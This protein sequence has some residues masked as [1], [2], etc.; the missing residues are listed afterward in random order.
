MINNSL[1]Y[2]AS[3]GKLGLTPLNYFSQ[4]F[5]EAELYLFNEFNLYNFIPNNPLYSRILLKNDHNIFFLNGFFY[6]KINKKN[7]EKALEELD[8]GNIEEIKRFI[9][10]L[11]GSYNG[12]WIDKRKQ[13]INIFTDIMG[14]D[15]I[16][17]CTHNDSLFLSSFIWPLLLLDDYQMDQNAIGEHLLLGHPLKN[18]TIFKNIKIIQPG[19]IERFDFSGKPLGF[20]SFENFP[21]RRKISKS[22]LIEDFFSRTKRHY[23]YIQSI[24]PAAKFGTTLTG[25]N[26]TRVVLNSMLNKNI[27]PYCT[28]GYHNSKSRDSERADKIA[29]HYKLNFDSINYSENFEKILLDTIEVSNG[30]TNGIWMGSISL[31]ASDKCDLLYNGFSGDFVAGGN[32]FNFNGMDYA[33]L[34]ENSLKFRANFKSILHAEI[35]SLADSSFNDFYKEYVSSY[36][37]YKSYSTEDLYFLQEKNERNFRRIASFADGIR[38]GKATPVFFFHDKQILDFYRSIDLKWYKQQRLHHKLSFHNNS[39]LAWMPSANKTN[40]PSFTVPYISYL[41]ENKVV[42]L[43]LAE[44]KKRK[45]NNF[46]EIKSVNDF[47]EFMSNEPMLK[48][49]RDDLEFIDIGAFINTIA[50]KEILY[51]DLDTIK[52]RVWDLCYTL[53]FVKE[54]KKKVAGNIINLKTKPF[55]NEIL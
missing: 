31:N 25:G 14:Y 55:S 13:E 11:N 17:Y 18:K 37:S 3:I 5:V 46:V 34:A 42:K 39:F 54:L 6:D 53:E 23:N 45:Q 38:L 8:E 1:Y 48:L 26:D 33:A 2:I 19:R 44:K 12:F 40:L 30:Y 49:N 51:S 29:K 4:N 47:L 20:E 7:L 22:D 27:K 43:Y 32:E 35:I 52:M 50:H 28:V 15:K 41:I 24:L 10:S 21:E 9:S 16:Y 36:E